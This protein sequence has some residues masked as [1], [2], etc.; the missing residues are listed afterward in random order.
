MVA[1]VGHI[2]VCATIKGNS[3]G[4]KKRRS[5]ACTISAASVT[6]TRYR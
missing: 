3:K 4:L 6:S 1:K 5:Y 2:E